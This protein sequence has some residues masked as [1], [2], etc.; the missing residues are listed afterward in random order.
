MSEERKNEVVQ[1]LRIGNL[2]WFAGYKGDHESRN[3]YV[4]S[5]KDTP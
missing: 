2:L 1:N 4:K 5:V 3:G